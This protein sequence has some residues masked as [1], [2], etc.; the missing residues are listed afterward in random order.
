MIHSPILFE[1]TIADTNESTDLIR[2]IKNMIV[3]DQ[4][5]DKMIIDHLKEDIEFLK[6]EMYT[7]NNVINNRIDFIKS[8]TRYV[9]T[10]HNHV[11]TILQELNRTE[12]GTE[13]NRLPNEVIHSPLKKSSLIQSLS[14]T[15]EHLISKE[16][17]NYVGD[18]NATND[19]IENIHDVINDSK[20]P[21]N[22][23]ANEGIKS[24]DCDKKE[25]IT[26]TN[27]DTWPLETI[28]IIGDSMIHGIDE[29]RLSKDKVIKVRSFPG[30]KIDDF[31]NYIVPL[32]NK[33]PKQV[34]FHAGT[35]DAIDCNSDEILNKL[36]NMKSY[37]KLLLP[38]CDVTLSYPIIRN[39][40]PKMSMEIRKLRNKLNLLGIPNISHENIDE[41]HLGKKGLHLNRKGLGRMAMNFISF[42]RCL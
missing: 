3:E 6:D 40:R 21:H 31:Y 18:Q 32:I 30:A 5:K 16:L 42:I 23:P 22:L 26:V 39:D 8:D 33:K 1:S 15:K 19:G 38:E 13:H 35:N 27:K 34:I 17:L 2:M 24:D 28:L 9:N 20:T 25:S 41:S 11:E 29:K 4:K 36:L 10:K 12:H 7:K 37:I 14:E